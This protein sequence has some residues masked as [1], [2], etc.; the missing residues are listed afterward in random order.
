MYEQ[1]NY[2]KRAIA[3]GQY[4]REQS[5]NST[6]V[7]CHMISW[8]WVTRVQP[9]LVCGVIAW[10]VLFSLD[11]CDI[12]VW[13]QLGNVYVCG[14]G[15]EGAIHIVSFSDAPSCYSG[16]DSQVKF[17][18]LL[19]PA[20]LALLVIPALA[21]VGGGHSRA[22]TGIHH[23]MFS[24][25]ICTVLVIAKCKPEE[26]QDT[27]DLSYCIPCTWQDCFVPPVLCGSTGWLPTSGY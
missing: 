27:V 20:F 7:L 9:P 2:I 8:L 14:G 25:C 24:K 12:Y 6:Q 18:I 3:S 1:A 19:L 26:V 5:A 17:T 15:G 22:L 21:V 4:I 13:Q 23:T 10:C 16:K 11:R